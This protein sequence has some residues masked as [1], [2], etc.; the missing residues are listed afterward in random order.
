MVYE[1]LLAN[2]LHYTLQLIE[3]LCLIRHFK[4][5]TG[6]LQAYSWHILHYNLFRILQNVRSLCEC[7]AI[8]ML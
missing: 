8:K 3:S 1:L 4:D 6:L 7:C 5:L 2:S